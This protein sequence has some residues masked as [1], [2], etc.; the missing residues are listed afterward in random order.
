MKARRITRTRVV[1]ELL[2]IWALIMV[3]LSPIAIFATSHGR[4]TAVRHYD[5]R[6][7]T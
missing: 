6:S 4:P 7:A 2:A 1:L 5:A 3:L